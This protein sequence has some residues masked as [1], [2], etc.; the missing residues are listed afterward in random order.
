VDVEVGGGL[1][2]EEEVGGIDEELD[3]VEAALLAAAEDAGFLVDLVLAEEEGAEDGAGV[4]F[5][6]SAVAGHDFLEDGL[7]DRAWRRGAG[8]SSRSWR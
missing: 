7:A 8:R 2:H 3:E 5:A 1:I 6:E 4:V